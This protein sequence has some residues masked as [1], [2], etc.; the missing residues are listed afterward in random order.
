MKY[1]VSVLHIAGMLGLMGCISMGSASEDHFKT[2][3]DS[4]KPESRSRRQTN[5]RCDDFIFETTC[6]S[7][8]AQ[9]YIN[10]LSKCGEQANHG[11]AAFNH[12]CAKTNKGKYCFNDLTISYIY[13]NCSTSLCSTGCRNTL[14]ESSC[15]A[16]GGPIGITQYFNNCREA[17]P[18]PCK[19]SLRIPKITQSPTCTTSEDYDKAIFIAYCENRSPIISALKRDGNCEEFIYSREVYCSIRNGKYCHLEELGDS[20]GLQLIETANECLISSNDISEC[21]H[22]IN[23]IKDMVGC[24]IH[25]SNRTGPRLFWPMVFNRSQWNQCNIVIPTLCNAASPNN[26]S[27][28]NFMFTVFISIFLMISYP[29]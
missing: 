18:S 5:N 6:S 7:S 29:Q 19:S 26:I 10:A 22:F 4:T 12:S 16:N 13:R 15:C 11:I 14:I 21:C 23:D 28:I 24:C 3:I 1:L 8:Y 20:P 2:Y 25:Y 9:N 27:F 17:V